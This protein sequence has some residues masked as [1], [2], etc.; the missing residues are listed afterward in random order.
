MTSYTGILEATL[1]LATAIRGLREVMR[2]F[3]AS[4]EHQLADFALYSLANDVVEHAEA[5]LLLQESAVPR[6]AFANARAAHEAA[7]D[8][9]IL[10]ADPAKYDF[11]A[12]QMRVFELFEVERLHRRGPKEA[13][14]DASGVRRRIEDV[15]VEKARA[16]DRVSPG[17]GGLLRSAW[18]RFDKV[19]GNLPLHWS[20]R[21]Q[22]QTVEELSGT[23]PEADD[24]LRQ[25]DFLWGALSIQTHARIRAGGRT[26]SV[27]G[28]RI[29]LS[30]VKSDKVLPSSVAY[31]ACEIA[32]KVLAKRRRWTTT[33]LTL[34]AI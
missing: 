27:N 32:A 9:D 26:I 24:V 19:Q 21:S 25:N 30:A 28:S 11:F 1:D 33:G 7:L 4:D 15:V 12:A 29:I 2:D 8:M 34:D 13:P 17:K 22:A 31:L 6:A 10:T 14:V 20:G 18:E 23:A 16:L 3:P 5:V